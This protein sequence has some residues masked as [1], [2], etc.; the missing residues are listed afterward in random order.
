MA[1]TIGSAGI[2]FND[3]TVQATKGLIKDSNTANTAT[4]YEIGVTIIASFVTESGAPP[5]RNA[6][7][8]VY[9]SSSANYLFNISSGTALNGTWRARGAIQTGGTNLGGKG[10]VPTEQLYV[11]LMQR[12]A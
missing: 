12:V 3:S 11:V 8:A 6:T 4:E 9:Y 7:Q 1:V 2:T 10:G 5:A